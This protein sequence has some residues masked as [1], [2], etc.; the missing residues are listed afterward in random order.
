MTEPSIKR[1]V[2]PSNVLKTLRPLKQMHSVFVFSVRYWTCFRL[3]NCS[4]FVLPKACLL[5][6]QLNIP[7]RLLHRVLHSLTFANATPLFAN[8]MLSK[9]APVATFCMQLIIFVAAQ[10]IRSL[11]F[12]A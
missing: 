10:V 2:L 11:N 1:I 7:P 9:A 8:Q 4:V 3:I 5:C 12:D 6:L